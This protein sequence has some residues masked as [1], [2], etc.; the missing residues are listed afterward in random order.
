M[1]TVFINYADQA[2]LQA[3]QLG[4]KTARAIGGFDRSLAMG[5]QD[6]D[7]A[8]VER[9]RAI[10]DAPR[11][12]GY[13]LWKP[14]L[15]LKTLRETMEEGDVL[16]YADAG[17]H[18]VGSAGPVVELCRRQPDETPLLLFSHEPAQHKNRAWTKRDCFHYM[19]LDAPPFLDAGQVAGTFLACRK[20][21]GGLAFIEEWLSYAQD[22]RLI[23][24]A[25]NECG[26]PNYPEFQDHRHDQSILS[27]LAVR[28]GI[29]TVPDISQW[30]NGR[31]PAEI[32]QTI[33][34]T[35]WWA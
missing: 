10:L 20:T 25:P 21:K 15:I 3:Q 33:A 22:P 4:I 35:R 9:N 19:G 27:L 11:G 32:P 1:A 26:L 17:C 7:P 23:T 34:H 2:F 13:W 14:H 8:F 28:H 16:F 24:D 18:F 31:R 29:A 30:G 12:A 6:L 5:R